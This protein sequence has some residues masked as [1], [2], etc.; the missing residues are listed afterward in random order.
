LY[1]YSK[2][3]T[4]NNNQKLIQENLLTISSNDKTI[5]EGINRAPIQKVTNMARRFA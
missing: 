1:Y 3:F 4:L 5:K 2:I